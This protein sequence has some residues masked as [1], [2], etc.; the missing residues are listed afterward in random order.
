MRGWSACSPRQPLPASAS[1]I[2]AGAIQDYGEAAER[3]GQNIALHGEFPHL[4]LQI[5]DLAL[6]VLDSRIPVVEH[7]A[8]VLQRL[9]APGGDLRG[10]DAVAGYQFAQRGIAPQRF[11]RHPS[12]ELRG[13]V[14]T[15]AFHGRYSFALAVSPLRWSSS[16]LNAARFFVQK[17]RPPLQD[18]DPCALASKQIARNKGRLVLIDYINQ[19]QQVASIVV[20]KPDT[21]VQ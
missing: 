7:F 19:T 5:P 17:A 10:V 21:V 20:P 18:E 13:V 11:Q 12:L 3:T 8:Q 15:S 9:L 16:P 14:P 4:G 2:F 1:E 6:G